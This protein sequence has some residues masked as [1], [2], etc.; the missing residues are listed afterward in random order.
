MTPAGF[1]VP[2]WAGRLWSA[3]P[4][5]K[6][7]LAMTHPNTNDEESD[8]LF[9]TIYSKDKDIRLITK[10]DY[11]CEIIF[12]G[13]GVWLCCNHHMLSQIHEVLERYY[14]KDMQEK[15]EGR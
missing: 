11:T 3:G 6:G 14:W 10:P 15:L 7:A 2:T 13:S 8:R 4:L 12:E 1:I 9:T 5:L